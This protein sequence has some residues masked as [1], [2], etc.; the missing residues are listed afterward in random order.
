[1][2]MSARVQ[3][4]SSDHGVAPSAFPDAPARAPDNDKE[5]TN[6]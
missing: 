2:Y 5:E 6:R 3:I 4:G 1:M